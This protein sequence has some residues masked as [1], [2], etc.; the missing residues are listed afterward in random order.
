MIDIVLIMF[1]ALCL[2][3]WIL[4]FMVTMWNYHR[5]PNLEQVQ[6]SHALQTLPF[7][8]V[9]VPTRNEAYRIVDCIKSLKYQSYKNLEI[10]IIDDSTDNT[11]EIIKEI[12]GNDK[13][14]IILKQEKLPKGWI[15]KPH[16]MQQASK[17]A[18]G[19]YLLFI[20]ADT[21]HEPQLISHAISHVLTEKIDLLSVVPRHLCMT[22]WEKVIQPIPLGLIPFISPLA[23]VN[24]PKSKVVVAFGPFMLIKRSVFDAVGGYATIKGKIAD[25]AEM[26]KLVKNSGYKVGLANAQSLMK[27][28]MYDSFHAVWEGWSKNI[29]MGLVQKRGITSH[30]FQILVAIAGAIGIFATM[31]FP[32]LFMIV[33]LYF[34]LLTSL[35]IWQHLLLFSGFIWLLTILIQFVVS[36]K[37]RIGSP[38]YSILS[39]LGG[40]ITIG[41]FLNS[42]IKAM[43]GVGVTWKGRIY[44]NST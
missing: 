5:L 8:S 10:I 37:Y 21:S 15:G 11:I 36:Y 24:N 42:A 35:N 44:H 20:D 17:I 38:I 29:F 33:S 7:V 6:S 27:I 41:I 14:F 19:E 43:S 31:V 22:F 9:I 25:D 1:L 40:F 13:R 16:A 23:Q 30:S 32:F 4:Y 2:I 3:A 26:A 18:K 12:I 28:R 39:F 34:Y